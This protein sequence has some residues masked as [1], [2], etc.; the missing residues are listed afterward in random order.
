MAEIHEL[1]KAV[2]RK[3]A[4]IRGQASPSVKPLS[5]IAGTPVHPLLD[6]LA[7]D[8]A[9]VDRLAESISERGQDVPVAL[10]HG[11]I[12]DGR[13]RAR[14]CAKLGIEPKTADLPADWDEQH[15]EGYILDA[16][17][18][19]KDAPWRD[20]VAAYLRLRHGWPGEVVSEYKPAR[21]DVARRVRLDERT[22]SGLDRLVAA[23]T[24]GTKWGVR[25]TA[26]GGETVGVRAAGQELD[27]PL[28]ESAAHSLSVPFESAQQV[29]DHEM[30]LVDQIAIRI[31]ADDRKRTRE[32]RAKEIQEAGAVDFQAKKEE[33]LELAAQRWAEAITSATEPPKGKQKVD[34]EERAARI[35]DGFALQFVSLLRQV[36]AHRDLELRHKEA[37]LQRVWKA[38]SETRKGV[39]ADEE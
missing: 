37:V 18:N 21:T 16:N 34:P 24:P 10:W 14:A 11:M 9:A 28:R 20:R 15:V 22:A 25:K 26:H 36:R 39:R 29:A 38:L 17:F 32:Q 12:V 3:Q 30:A 4:E 7:I 27:E 33:Q 6:V 2:E 8:N 1:R 35:V 13:H 19:R 31:A 23:A 5:D